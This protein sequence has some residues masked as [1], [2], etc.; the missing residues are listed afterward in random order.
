MK[1]IFTAALL[2]AASSLVVFGQTESRADLLKAIEAKRADLSRLEQKFLAPSDEDR[3]AYAEF[4]A[5]PDTGLMRLLPREV[6]DSVSNKKPALTL[7]GGGSYYSFTLKTNEYGNATD[8]GLEQGFLK[9]GFAGA[10]YGMLIKLEGVR[11]EEVSIELPGVIFLAK[12]AAVTQEPE[13][14]LE[15]RRFSTGTT[16]EGMPYKNRLPVEV[17]STYALRS[18]NFSESDV[19]VTFRVVREDTDGSIIIAWKLLRKY[20]TPKLARNN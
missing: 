8:I 7:R 10:D 11:L 12:Y 4:L 2:I 5:Q 9:A 14:R 6:Y 16:I 13:A 20:P 19:L 15:Q 1:R 18:V 17:G 3:V